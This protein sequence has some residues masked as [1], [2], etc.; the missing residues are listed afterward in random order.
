[1]TVAK[2]QRQHQDVACWTRVTGSIIAHF[3]IDDFRKGRYSK[4]HAA[5]LYLSTTAEM[6]PKDGKGEA[7]SKPQKLSGE[8]PW[9]GPVFFTCRSYYPSYLSRKLLV[10]FVLLAQRKID[11]QAYER[12]LPP[13]DLF[14]GRCYCFWVGQKKTTIHIHDPSRNVGVE[15]L[16]LPLLPLYRK[17][18]HYCV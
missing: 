17:F 16:S 6:V 18:R 11:C 7:K 8:P 2:C 3:K 5:F 4:E 1:M 10:I 9:E 13:G 14:R 12:S 15:P